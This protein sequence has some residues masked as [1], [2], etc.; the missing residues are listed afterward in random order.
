M[1]K[2]PSLWEP[3]IRKD[4]A[5]I[6]GYTA[7]VMRDARYLE[8]A[9]EPHGGALMVPI[10][11][12]YLGLPQLKGIDLNSMVSGLQSTL[13]LRPEFLEFHRELKKSPHPAVSGLRLLCG[14]D[15]GA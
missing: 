4:P 5:Q 13:L 1:Q 8:A 12:H 11:R 3:A 6:A 2:E 15:G 14:D 9:Y 7:V 10:S